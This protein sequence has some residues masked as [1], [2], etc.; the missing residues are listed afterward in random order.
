MLKEY[1]KVLLPDPDLVLDRVLDRVLSQL[2]REM[3]LNWQR[4]R[5]NHKQGDN[6]KW[7]K[8]DQEEGIV[9]IEGVIMVMV[10]MI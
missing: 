2:K 1:L 8:K 5:H 6:K 9:T 10:S 3:P 4:Q 7:L